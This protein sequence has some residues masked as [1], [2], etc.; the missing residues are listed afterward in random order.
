ML[1]RW[2]EFANNKNVKG[3]YFLLTDQAVLQDKKL[4][5][6]LKELEQEGCFQLVRYYEKHFFSIRGDQQIDIKTQYNEPISLSVELSDV[7][8]K[9]TDSVK[10]RIFAEQNDYFLLDD[11]I[12]VDGSATIQVT[13]QYKP[14][15]Y[16]QENLPTD[17]N[18]KVKIYFEQ[19]EKDN[20]INQL[21]NSSCEWSFVNK[22]QKILNITI[23]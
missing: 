14:L 21:S 13:P 5:K 9:I 23:K 16:L 3:Y 11:I 6:L 17:K 4:E 2:C 15:E 19:I 10:V 22:E 20:S 1:Q 7:Q 18:E 12:S 8:K